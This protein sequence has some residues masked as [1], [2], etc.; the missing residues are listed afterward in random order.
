MAHS[1]IT[2]ASTRVPCG[3]MKIYERSH[4]KSLSV[5]RL[6]KLCFKGYS[7]DLKTKK[8]FFGCRIAENE[9]GG[10]MNVMRSEWGTALAVGKPIPSM[11]LFLSKNQ[12]ATQK[13]LYAPICKKM[14]VVSYCLPRA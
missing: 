13:L 11:E 7:F 10:W 9:P 8:N 14:S 2:Y 12:K 1:Q 3:S 4:E 6:V 5:I